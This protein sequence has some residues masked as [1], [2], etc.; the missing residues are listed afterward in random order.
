M[1]RHPTHYRKNQQGGHQHDPL[2]VW[3]APLLD[4]GPTTAVYPY[5]QLRDIQTPADCRRA[6]LDET[7][8][9]ETEFGMTILQPLYELLWTLNCGAG[10]FTSHTV[11]A[12]PGHRAPYDWAKHY[13]AVAIITLSR[14]NAEHFEQDA[15]QQ[16]CDELGRIIRATAPAQ[17][18]TGWYLSVGPCNVIFTTDMSVTTFRTTLPRDTKGFGCQLIIGGAASN[19]RTAAT[20][21]SQATTFVNNNIKRTQTGTNTVP[22]P[23][24]QHALPGALPTGS[25]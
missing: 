4:E 22:A 6:V 19:R 18:H 23:P 5:A 14:N 11:V 10:V 13:V 8:P 25:L 2:R 24:H 7:S 16:S 12:K 20:R 1:T 15:C 21:W 3:R 17:D 9:L